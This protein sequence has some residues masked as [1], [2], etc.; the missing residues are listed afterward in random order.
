MELLIN[1]DFGGGFGVSSKVLVKLLELDSVILT[2]HTLN[3][4]GYLNLKDFIRNDI[5]LRDYNISVLL[6][7]DIILEGIRDTSCIYS[8]GF[9][10]TI[11]N[12]SK[13]VRTNIDIINIV[14][15]LGD[16][17]NRFN[18]LLKIVNIPDNSNFQINEYDGKEFVELLK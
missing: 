1:V 2:K 18:S 11:D 16:K 17:A 12:T 7:D 15:E 10:Y 6:G 14:R 9:I 13:E 8:K 3:E 5:K 4:C